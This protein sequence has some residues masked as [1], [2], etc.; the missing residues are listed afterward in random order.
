VLTAGKPVISVA[1]IELAGMFKPSATGEQWKP[2][3]SRQR[4][5]TRR[6]GFLLSARGAMPP[7][8]IDA[9]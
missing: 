8:L 5:M 7:G 9:F 6:L 2:F 3:T 4:V 1:T